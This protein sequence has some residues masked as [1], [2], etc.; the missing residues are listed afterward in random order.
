MIRA[1]SV[2]EESSDV[3]A[4]LDGSSV[5]FSV[6]EWDRGA[7]SQVRMA[8]PYAHRKGQ[9]AE[10]C[11]GGDQLFAAPTYSWPVSQY[12]QSVV[13]VG[14][15]SWRIFLCSSS[16]LCTTLLLESVQQVRRIGLET[17]ATSH[18]THATHAAHA[19]HASRHL[20]LLLGDFCNYGLSS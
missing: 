9:E 18:A 20:L 13:E 10:S 8:P 11:I 5:F 4:G 14:A 1:I 6:V 17:H 19:T 12:E 16:T 2:E 7:Q 15:G 3:V